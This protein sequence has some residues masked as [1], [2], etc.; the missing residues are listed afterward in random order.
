MTKIRTRPIGSNASSD[1]YR[2]PTEV[3]PAFGDFALFLAHTGF[4]NIRRTPKEP[5]ILPIFRSVSELPQRFREEREITCGLAVAS[6]HVAWRLVSQD[7]IATGNRLWYITE[8]HRFIL[9]LQ[10]GLSP[11]TLCVLWDEE[12]DP[13]IQSPFHVMFRPAPMYIS[14]DDTLRSSTIGRGAARPLFN[15][16]SLMIPQYLKG[17]RISRQHIDNRINK[18][19]AEGSILPIRDLGCAHTNGRHHKGDPPAPCGACTGSDL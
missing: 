12:D 15:A 11:G 17:H 10:H 8:Q 3:E 14:I 2:L 18:L 16:L 1:K 6:L 4:T 5:G 7:L 13:S 9:Y 19:R